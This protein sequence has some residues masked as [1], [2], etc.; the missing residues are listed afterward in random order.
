MLSKWFIFTITVVYALVPGPLF[1]YECSKINQHLEKTKFVM[2]RIQA[3][4]NSNKFS[5]TIWYIL[6]SGSLK[7]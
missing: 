4:E 6:A 3:A 5:S 1:Y 7:Q 2:V